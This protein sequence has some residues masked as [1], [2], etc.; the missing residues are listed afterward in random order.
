[1]KPAPFTTEFTYRGYIVTGSSS[2]PSKV[3]WKARKFRYG[4]V[5]TFG[6][7]VAEIIDYI[8]AREKTRSLLHKY[9]KK[10]N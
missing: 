3:F 7:D 1:M 9:D 6:T 10:P 5:Q 4:C 8:D 2:G